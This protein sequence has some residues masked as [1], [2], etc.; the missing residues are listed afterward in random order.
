[1]KPPERIWTT[2][3]RFGTFQREEDD[4]GE[5][6]VPYLREDLAAR[7]SP[8]MTKVHRAA[9]ELGMRRSRDAIDRIRMRLSQ[10]PG[11]V[12]RKRLIQIVDEEAAK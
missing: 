11:Q 1:M 2:G 4:K 12:S 5:F 3:N 10:L 9:F 7:Y 6:S 8:D